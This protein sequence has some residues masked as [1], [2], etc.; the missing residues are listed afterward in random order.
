M[1]AACCCGA[2]VE[3]EAAHLAMPSPFSVT[4][5]FSSLALNT[6]AYLSSLGTLGLMISLVYEY[7]A[8][9][10]ESMRYLFPRSLNTLA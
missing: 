4:S 7:E 6:L 9:Y 8:Y 3:L 1:R 10:A 5:R 2:R